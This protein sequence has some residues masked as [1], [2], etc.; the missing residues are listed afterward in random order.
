M[1]L[2]LTNTRAR[3]ISP[4]PPIICVLVITLATILVVGSVAKATDLYRILGLQLYDQQFMFPMVG[5]AFLLCF[6]HLTPRGAGALESIRKLPPIWDR[7]SLESFGG[8]T[9]EGWQPGL[10]PLTTSDS[11]AT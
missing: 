9:T 3:Q 5:V 7:L 4:A 11:A 10:S 2:D 1:D 6:V 8:I